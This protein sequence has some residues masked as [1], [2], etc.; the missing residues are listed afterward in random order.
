VAQ[1]ALR[2]RTRQLDQ[3]VPVL[4]GRKR[5]QGNARFTNMLYQDLLEDRV[6]YMLHHNSLELG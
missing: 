4:N 5:E 3:Y 1:K 2:M 6:S